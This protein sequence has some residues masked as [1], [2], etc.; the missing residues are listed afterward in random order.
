MPAKKP[1]DKE[2]MDRYKEVLDELKSQ[3][4]DAMRL[5]EKGEKKSLP[6]FNKIMTKIR[7][8]K[9]YHSEAFREGFS[10]TQINTILKTRNPEVTLEYLF[11]D[12]LSTD[13]HLSKLV[14]N[15]H[16]LQQITDIA[17]RGGRASLYSLVQIYDGKE[18]TKK[19]GDLYFSPTQFTTMART[20][21]ATENLKAVIN[22]YKKGYHEKTITTLKS[23]PTEIEPEDVVQITKY[24]AGHENLRALINYC[25]LDKDKDEKSIVAN[26]GTPLLTKDELIKILASAGG[27]RCLAAFLKYTEQY[28]DNDSLNLSTSQLVSIASYD[29]G[30]DAIEKLLDPRVRTALEELLKKEPSPLST[31]LISRIAASRAGAAALDAVIKYHNTDD[32]EKIIFGEINKERFNMMTARSGGVAKRLALITGKENVEKWKRKYQ[33]KNTK[34]DPDDKDYWAQPIIDIVSSSTMSNDKVEDKLDRGIIPE[35]K[36]RKRSPSEF[37]NPKNDFQTLLGIIENENPQ[38]P[39]IPSAPSSPPE[40]SDHKKC[41]ASK[42]RRGCFN[43]QIENRFNTHV[44]N[45]PG[46]EALLKAAF[47]HGLC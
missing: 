27:H 36:K 16:N 6:K 8:F 24:E 5:V 31:D 32:N 38:S 28:K 47:G 23:G 7:L 29:T 3:L 41:S 21:G 46:M 22:F 26:A 11:D 40:V 12:T 44:T 37:F 45:T 15:G 33:N 9:A 10:Y 30:Y 4:E 13:S 42:R 14:G 25:G 39:D 35:K 43:P 34:D 17:H 20:R 1:N 18:L 19:S 2:C